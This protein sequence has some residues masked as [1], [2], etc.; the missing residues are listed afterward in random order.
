MAFILVVN[1]SY[2]FK[3]KQQRLSILFLQPTMVVTLKRGRQTRIPVQLKNKMPA[4]WATS[5]CIAS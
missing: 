1:S 4:R 2:N 5:A 3:D